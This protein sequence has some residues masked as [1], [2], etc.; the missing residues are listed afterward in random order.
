M[1]DEEIDEDMEEF[2]QKFKKDVVILKDVAPLLNRK[3]IRDKVGIFYN[4]Y[5]SYQ[6][7]RFTKYLSYATAILALTAILQ[8]INAIYGKEIA[9]NFIIEVARIL[10][11]I[12]IF[13]FVLKIT[14]EIL[15]SFYI[16]I[17]NKFNR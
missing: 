15:D 14:V 8:T 3:E 10:I 13:I 1:S 2:L 12:L 9:Q 11:S 16:W 17:K 7:A 5:H 4:A 6:I